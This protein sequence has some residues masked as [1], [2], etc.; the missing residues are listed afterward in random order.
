MRLELTMT[1]ALQEYLTAVSPPEPEALRPLRE[2]TGFLGAHLM[3]VPPQEARFLATL[4]RAIGARRT[5]EVGVFTGYSLLATALALPPDGE[6]VAL[7]ISEEWT[8]L[9]MAHCRRA[10]VAD[11]IDLRL[12][13]ARDTLAAL[14][15]EAGAVGS[16]D[17]AFIDADKEG[18]PEYFDQALT[19]LRPRGVI[20]VDNVLWGGAVADPEVTD[21][22]TNAVR[23]FNERMRSDERVDYT[24]LPLADG[25]TI[26]VK[27]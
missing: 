10:G 21:S 18:Y 11:R 12:G 1:E 24:L 7:D 22:E 27:R 23:A 2:E 3:Q 26:A 15:G 20:V 8:S 25:M 17:F 19:L 14:V 13:D 5:L 4:V 16:F 9:A 6:V